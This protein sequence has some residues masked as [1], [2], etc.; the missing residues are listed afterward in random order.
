VLL[1]LWPDLRILVNKRPA[2]DLQTQ[3]AVLNT[4]NLA[5]AGCDVVSALFAHTAGTILI[6]KRH[7]N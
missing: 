4:L 1:R 7:E 3:A 2:K 5:M 6:N